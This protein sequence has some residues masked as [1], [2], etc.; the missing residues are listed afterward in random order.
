MG[1]EVSDIE[2]MVR[3]LVAGRVVFEKYPW[4]QDS[5]L[6]IWP[7]RW[8]QSKAWFKDPDGNV[9][10]QPACEGLSL[11][12]ATGDSTALGRPGE[13][14]SA[15]ALLCRKLAWSRSAGQRRADVPRSLWF[16]RGHSGLVKGRCQSQGYELESAT[17]A[18]PR[19]IVERRM[20]QPARRGPFSPI[21]VD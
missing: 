15:R 18:S 10:S 1:W 6:G 5:E 11:V 9:L 21:F 19:G 14:R 17:I 4:V 3:W 12:Q 2:A 13:R 16:Y 8:R 7:A 20:I